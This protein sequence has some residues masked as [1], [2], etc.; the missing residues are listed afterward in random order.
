MGV[1]TT[2]YAYFK[3]ATGID[4]VSE[5]LSVSVQGNQLSITGVEGPIQVFDQLGRQV[6]ISDPKTNS[7]EHKVTL[8]HPGVYILRHKGISHK[9]LVMGK[10]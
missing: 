2:Y 3:S 7:L 4:A 9:V 8:P 1:S 10:P 5:G 6:Y